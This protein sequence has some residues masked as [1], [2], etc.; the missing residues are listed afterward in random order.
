M[1]T[2]TALPVVAPFIAAALLVVAR[3]L[4]RRWFNDLSSAAVV[5]SVVAICAILL[6]RSARQ[7]IAYWMGGWRPAHEVTIGISL[8]IDPIGAMNGATTGSAVTVGIPDA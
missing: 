7:P 3:P 5:A 6:S 4:T 8:S 2:V 1:P